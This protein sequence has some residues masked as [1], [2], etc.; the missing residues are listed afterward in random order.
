MPNKSF[1]SKSYSDVY[2]SILWT[3]IN[4]KKHILHIYYTLWKY[5][6]EKLEE[7]P[8]FPFD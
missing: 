6:R 3:L 4:K 7:K 1:F 5:H 2:F 8:S